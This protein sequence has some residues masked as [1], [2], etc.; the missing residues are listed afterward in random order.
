M[1]VDSPP[2]IPT[3]RKTFTS[4]F[5]LNLPS[6]SL[7]LHKSSSQPPTLQS[8]SDLGKQPVV[9]E[10]VVRAE[11]LVPSVWSSDTSKHASV[12]SATKRLSLDIKNKQTDTKALIEQP[13]K[14]IE[15]TATLY[16]PL[17]PEEVRRHQ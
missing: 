9:N 4:S 15:E 17:K 7:N 6:I 2:T 1:E 14:Q 8:K 13:P 5:T 12:L 16:A 3:V 11:P 10:E